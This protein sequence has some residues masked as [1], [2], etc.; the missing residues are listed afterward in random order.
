MRE[1][2]D[3]FASAGL[4]AGIA[5]VPRRAS[6]PPGAISSNGPLP[7]AAPMRRLGPYAALD[8]CVSIDCHDSHA[9]ADE[10]ERALGS[11]TGH[12]RTRQPRPARAR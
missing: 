3:R 4:L 11:L 9:V 2:I 6:D 10:I 8:L 12:R 5:G 1:V 7:A